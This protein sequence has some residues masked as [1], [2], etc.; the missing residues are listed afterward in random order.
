M[1]QAK[2]KVAKKKAAVKKKTVAKKTSAKKKVVKKKVARKKVVKKKVASP[3]TPGKKVTVSAEE[4]HQMVAECAYYRAINSGPQSPEA[5]RR[6]W[7]DAEAE[8]DALIRS[9]SD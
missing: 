3:K 1:A 7:L 4:R 5:D 8:I 9:R 6:H 2:K